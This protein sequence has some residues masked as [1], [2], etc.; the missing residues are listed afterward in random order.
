MRDALRT[1]DLCTQLTN[2]GG[3]TCDGLV[4]HYHLSPEEAV[5]WIAC[6]NA[7]VALPDDNAQAGDFLNDDEV[8]G[9]VQTRVDAGPE[10]WADG[11]FELATQMLAEWDENNS[12]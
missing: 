8:R 1:T 10:S 2:D 12:S 7:G 9:H 5:L 3:L 6:T 11:Y 4:E